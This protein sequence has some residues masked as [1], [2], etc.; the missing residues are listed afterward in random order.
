MALLVVDRDPHSREAVRLLLREMGVGVILEAKSGDEALKTLAQERSK[1]RFI[2]SEYDIPDLD[3]IAFANR[4]SSYP[5]QHSTPF[6]MMTSDE[7]Y[8]GKLK[9]LATGDSRVDGILL[10]PFRQQALESAMSSGVRASKRP[11][12]PH[13]LFRK[14]PGLFY[15]AHL[16]PSR[17]WAIPIGKRRDGRS[18]PDELNE[19]VKTEGPRIGALVIEPALCG[20]GERTG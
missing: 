1:I 8:R 2:L 5:E 11:A 19:I 3:G 18:S 16:A 9:N 7:L 12:S 17:R 15:S 6:L 4:L 14:R 20:V 10:K 13:R